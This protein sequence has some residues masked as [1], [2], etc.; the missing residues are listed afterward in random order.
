MSNTLIIALGCFLAKCVWV[1]LPACNHAHPPASLPSENIKPIS[2]IQPAPTPMNDY[3]PIPL[4]RL[5]GIAEHVLY[6]SVQSV[7]K[8]TIIFKVEE[9][10]I[11]NIPKNKKIDIA[12]FIPGKADGPREVPYQQGQHFLLFLKMDTTQQMLRIL[13]AGGEG[14]MPV[15]EGF[16]YFFG[17]HV[18]GLERKNYTVHSKERAI[19]R[20]DYKTFAEAVREFRKCY[21]YQYVPAEEKYKCERL[22]SPEEIQRMGNKSFIHKYLTDRA[23]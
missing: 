16:V 18:E 1:I 15:E 4:P 22:C 20:F 13:G 9:S 2:A 14:E 5:I 8:E 12:Q 17:R 3:D 6:G 21:S 23:K 7:K 11:G 19:Q 10:L